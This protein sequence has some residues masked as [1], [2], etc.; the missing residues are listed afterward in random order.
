[1]ED[2]E[3]K[4]IDLL[5]DQFWK[6]GYLTISRRY[7]TYLPEPGKVGSFNVDIVA[8]YKNDYAIGITINRNDLFNSN[9]V[10]KITYLATRRTKFSNK[11]VRLFIGV[12]IEYF[13]QIRAV[14]DELDEDTRRNIKLCQIVN[15]SLPSTMK[16]RFEANVLFS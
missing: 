2:N 4:T 12:P 9:F 11:R 5:V 10:S 14:V 8:R 6:K 3:R 16:N 1:M 15:K 13:K 7:G